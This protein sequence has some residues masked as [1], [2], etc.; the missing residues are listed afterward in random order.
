MQFST[1]IGQFSYC[2]RLI[3]LRFRML[4]ALWLMAYSK[5]KT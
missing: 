2:L 3:V 5:R 4:W 1:V